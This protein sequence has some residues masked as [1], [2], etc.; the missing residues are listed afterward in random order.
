MDN[1][2]KLHLQ[3]SIIENAHAFM[4]GAEPRSLQP[5]LETAHAAP[6]LP[7]IGSTGVP[8]EL[9]RR[10]PD[11]RRAE[12]QLHAATAEIGVAVADMYPRISLT[13][14]FVQQA[15]HPSDLTE[16]GA[17][18]WMIGPSISVPIF[19][20]GRLRATLELRK[21]QQQVAAVNYQRTVLG[22]WHEIDNALDAYGAELRRNGE[23]A[24][25]ARATQNAYESAH[26][27]YEHGLVD[28][29]VDLNAHRALLQAQRALSESTT[30]IGVQLVALCKSLGGGWSA[31]E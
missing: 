26:V 6:T 23:L 19:Q 15:L 13:G 3:E 20:A 31:A 24:G 8:S 11:I 22:A 29:S 5:L 28:S 2:P 30:Q 27:R 12:E 1:I 25:G 16:W 18:Q 7:A 10:R 9:A 4:F 14:S 17:R 21:I